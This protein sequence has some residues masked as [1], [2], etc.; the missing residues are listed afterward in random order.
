MAVCEICSLR[1]VCGE[2]EEEKEGQ[3]LI[4]CLMG[5]LGPRDC[6]VVGDM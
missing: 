5:T 1:L 6:D 3:E 2:E 4:I